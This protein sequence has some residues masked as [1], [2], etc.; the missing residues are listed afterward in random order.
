MFRPSYSE[1]TLTGCKLFEPRKGEMTRGWM[2]IIC[3][4]R[5]IDSEQVI[6]QVKSSQVKSGHVI[7]LGQEFHT[8]FFLVQ[9]FC[10]KGHLENK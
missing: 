10:G 9:K 8:E 1:I 2:L 6:Q 5:S 3:I 4:I 7:R